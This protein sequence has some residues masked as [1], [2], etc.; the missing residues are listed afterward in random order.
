[1]YNPADMYESYGYVHS[2][3]N[4][5]VTV[6]P[7]NDD[8]GKR[9]LPLNLIELTMNTSEPRLALIRMPRYLAEG[10]GLIRNPP[11]TMAVSYPLKE[12]GI[13][14]GEASEAKTISAK[15]AETNTARAGES[16]TQTDQRTERQP[17]PEKLKSTAI[18]QSA[19]DEAFEKAVAGALSKHL[20][21]IPPLSQQLKADAEALGDTDTK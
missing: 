21:I 10:N 11:Q 19:I 1:M 14:A 6:T 9:Y 13:S 16:Q 5:I 17:A 3:N 8:V 7:R 15:P 2:V 18:H 4:G 20:N 12:N